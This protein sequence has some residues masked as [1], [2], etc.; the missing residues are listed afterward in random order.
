[1][2]QI[3]KRQKSLANH[4]KK[5][6]AVLLVLALIL[7]TF[8]TLSISPVYAAGMTDSESAQI[9]KDRI[10]ATFLESDSYR[11]VSG[12]DI[13]GYISKSMEYA[14]TIQPDGSWSDVNYADRTN[15]ANG[16]LW[17]PYY[18]LYRITAMAMG[19]NQE[20]NEAYHNPVIKD[21]IE[22]A[23]AYW[24]SVKP[25]STNWWENE[26]GQAMCMG[27]TG[28][29][30]EGVI[31]KQALDVCINYNQGRLDTVGANGVWRTQDYLYK[32]LVQNDYPEITKGI[33]TL[34]E[35]LAVDQTG[36]SIEA[37]QADSSFYCHGAKLYS[38][39]Y[40]MAQFN[41][42]AKW[43][44]YTSGTNFA[45]TEEALKGLEFY[46]LDG[47]RWMIRGELGFLYL[48]YRRYNT[49]E[50]VGSYAADI[51]PGMMVMA[52]YDTDP[53][54][55]AEYQQLVDNIKGN[56]ATNGLVGNKHF[57]RSDYT[58]QMR[59]NYGIMTKMSSSR[60]NGGE[61]RSTF[62][63]S[64][65]NE[66][67]WNAAGTTAIFVNG[68]EYTDLVPAFNWS[69]YPG[70]TAPNE[71]MPYTLECRFNANSSFVGGVSDGM[72][73]ASVF[74]QDMD[75][76][77]ARKGYFY[78]DDEMVALGAG[79]SST[80][81]VEVHTTVNQAIAKNNA[82]ID[83]VQVPKGTAPVTYTNPKWAYNDQI[84]YVFPAD[85]NVSASNM[86]Q[87]GSWL[88]QPSQTKQAFTL[89]FNHGINPA[90]AS[91]QY[92]VVPGKDS[93]EVEAY[94]SNIPVQILSNTTELQ[95]VRNEGLKQTQLIFYTA[96]SFEYRTGAT[97]TVN[98]P[99]LA[100]IDESSGTPKVTVS[101]PETPGL[102][103]DVKITE[104]DKDTLYG[105]YNLG[106]GIYMGQSLTQTLSDIP[107]TASNI[108]ASSFLPGYAPLNA[109]DDSMD[110]SWRSEPDES[111]YI[112]YNIDT[113]NPL[114]DEVTVDWGA[115]YAK[116]YIVQYSTDNVN[117]TDGYLQWHGS[118]GKEVIDLPYVQAKYIRILMLSSNKKNGYDIKDLN[119]HYSV[120]LALYKPSSTSGN[121]AGSMATYAND[122]NDT[123]RWSGPTSTATPWW[124]VN[125]GAKSKVR[126]IRISW[127]GSYSTSFK[128]QT[129]DDGG[130]W[131]DVN[132]FTNDR[133]GVQILNF[134]EG[135][136]DARYIRLQS[137]S[138]VDTRYGI[139]MYEFEVFGEADVPAPLPN[140]GG[141]QNLAYGKTVTV[142][143][144]WSNSANIETPYTTTI[145][146]DGDMGTRT[147]TGRGT[148]NVTERSFYVDLGQPLSINEIKLFWESNTDQVYLEYSDNPAGPW[149][150]IPEIN[151][152]RSTLKE[153]PKV[154]QDDA[155]FKPLT[156]RYIRARG[157]MNT[158]YG[159]AVWEF[160]VYG[161]Y[162]YKLD[163]HAV[164]LNK[165]DTLDLK[166]L[167]APYSE[168]DSADFKSYNTDAVTVGTPAVSG[169]SVPG[170]QGT[171]TAR[172]EAL[173][174]GT[175]VIIVRHS[176]GSEYDLCTVKVN[177]YKIDLQA[178]YDIASQFDQND[179]ISSSWTAS[180]IDTALIN[181]NAALSDSNATQR[182]V[183][184][185]IQNLQTAMDKLEKK[186]NKASL[187]TVISQIKALKQ[188]DYTPE[189]WEKA[190]FE[191]LLADANS[192]YFND[193]ATQQEIDFAVNAIIAA[194]NGLVKVT[195][196]GEPGLIT[197]DSTSKS[198]YRG[199]EFTI[200]ATITSPG[201]IDSI[202]LFS[203][204]S[205]AVIVGESETS[206]PGGI[207]V[208]HLS[209]AKV[210]NAIITATTTGGGIARC[211]VNVLPAGVVFD[212]AAKTLYPGD[213]FTLTATVVPEAAVDKEVSF[214]V[215]NSIVSLGTP[216]YDAQNGKTTV[217]VTAIRTGTTTITATTADGGT[218]Q[219]EIT[220]QPYIDRDSGGGNGG[221]SGGSSTN[222]TPPPA[223]PNNTISDA[224]ASGHGS[225]TSTIAAAAKTDKDGK[226]TAA[227]TEKEVTEAIN[228]VIEA[229]AKMEK[230]TAAN[231]EIKVS[232]PSDAKAVEVTLPK[233][234]VDKVVS[235]KIAAMTVSTPIAV[236]SFDKESVKTVSQAATGDVKIT[237]S[238]VDS[239]TLSDEVKRT[240][241]GR[242]VVDLSVT[243]GGKTISEFAG[244]VTVSIPYTSKAGEDIEAI[245]IYCINSQG[246]LEIVSNCV[247]NKETEMISFKTNNLLE[248]AVG[249]NKVS[250]KD[251]ADGA[252]Y[253][254]AVDFIAARGITTGTGNGNFSPGGK[255]TRG[256]FLTMVMKAYEIKA[257]EKTADNFTDAG[258]KF[259][260]GYLAAAKRLG[261]SE[262][263]GNNRF[264]PEKEIT[265]EEMF[266]LLYN[267]LKLIDEV[268]A[269]N[270]GMGLDE[271]SD[272]NEIAA[273]AKPAMSMFAEN[274]IIG[275]N[276]GRISPKDTTNRAQMAQV[277]YNL[278]KNQMQ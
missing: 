258:N 178:L 50:G 114:V 154:V 247:Y 200:T 83:G 43:V 145:P 206:T 208:V 73:G 270:S 225:V 44:G 172:L 118:G 264:A 45:F 30:M 164:T 189:S 76:T 184:A 256:E 75:N 224:T 58:S 272:T 16:T 61:Y 40:G 17:S 210:G 64:V 8:S 57:W 32:K 113:P 170:G 135:S 265:R 148:A 20:G 259:Y 216:S 49:T 109:I 190:D 238:R 96:G 213:S 157:V 276:L 214:R 106:S 134:P 158:K 127:E 193:Y 230:G 167:I 188:A 186:A 125:L 255:L 14:N 111:Q 220:V 27:V 117:W 156:A 87:T 191:K 143:S 252:W 179:Y 144:S 163:K 215:G 221:G 89:Y 237:A 226:A 52:Q 66:I 182:Q 217:Q 98:Q 34:G 112:V 242:P 196:P 209:A 65:G 15:S 261:I 46:I 124:Q 23:L 82:S 194:M 84:G 102:I 72:Y 62:R 69:H 131:T 24:D 268:P 183:D 274:G 63:P 151:I 35:T 175:S 140:Y 67:Y 110:T 142:D 9:V 251:V 108:G 55:R 233:A 42:V 248:Y 121:D 236:M 232:A 130:T 260:T 95:A 13:F 161:D 262:G 263:V 141:R 211:A 234:A 7:T 180:D 54:R 219:C 223:A 99:C 25:S 198:V 93:A 269:G 91:Y 176:A 103:V 122:G 78:F 152:V 47:T 197:L 12:S 169:D 185:E 33:A 192:V 160:E 149:T 26:I 254:K 181:A 153:S 257:D 77:V 139:S 92:I 71:K 104:T 11:V 218:A 21:A 80:R 267:I 29:F 250:F 249:Y 97:I 119:V 28:I 39:G 37:V 273:W 137:I 133:P 4:L 195:N 129:S 60:I 128:I 245:V 241:G 120:N 86:D 94:S 174:G 41:M 205:D 70:T 199:Q 202:V 244:N 278:I 275:G 243:S 126:T 22:R 51:L 5:M 88:D 277:L 165:G 138:R 240:A 3:R 204:D 79:I 166:A 31:S 38:E 107:I 116:E 68:R 227:V 36:T 271:F 222:T 48:G 132:T 105:R 171:Y 56:S 239:T 266:A 150:L 6:T 177:T 2:S 19:Y 235:N 187:V 81:P 207:T 74:T 212:T 146:T 1:M 229:A 168:T 173:S 228:K 85:S 123:T 59:D 53:E 155:K 162:S 231:V 101:N 253:S 201:A 100:I 18:A 10:K 246:G 136:I 147:S 90:N 115:D 203:S 159:L